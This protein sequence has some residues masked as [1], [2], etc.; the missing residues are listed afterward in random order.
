MT[1]AVCRQAISILI[2]LLRKFVEMIRIFVR[3]CDCAQVAV[4]TGM[5]GPARNGLGE[6]DSKV[7]VLSPTKRPNSTKTKKKA[8]CCGVSI[9]VCSSFSS[10]EARTL[11]TPPSP[12]CWRLMKGGACS[13][14]NLSPEN[15]LKKYI[16]KKEGKKTSYSQSIGASVRESLKRLEASNDFLPFLFSFF[17]PTATFFNTQGTPSP[18]KKICP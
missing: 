5:R 2:C 13:S 18:P 6:A 14:A 17:F 11:L 12:A 1:V 15:G 9:L 3:L 16:R 7:N 4:D 10:H 8:G